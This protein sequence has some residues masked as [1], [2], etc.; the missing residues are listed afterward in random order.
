MNEGA[1]PPTPPLFAQ[2][3]KCY[4]GRSSNET[5]YGCDC[6]RFNGCSGPYCNE[7][8]PVIISV[9]GLAALAITWIVLPTII[10]QAIALYKLHKAGRLKRSATVNCL[11]Y[12]MLSGI[13]GWCYIIDTWMRKP[14]T[15]APAEK[16]GGTDLAYDYIVFSL[17]TSLFAMFI[18]LAVIQILLMWIDV[19]SKS[20]SMQKA[21]TGNSLIEVYRKV[22]RIYAA[23]FVFVFFGLYLVD[24]SLA[25]LWTFLTCIVLQVIM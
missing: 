3:F 17:F 2:A 15:C 9:M 10:R 14:S 5:E 19:Y 1:R 22:L 21:Q 7:P 13:F 23:L 20:K 18:V 8:S 6:F 11:V 4:P 16:D 24:T 12:N 25:V